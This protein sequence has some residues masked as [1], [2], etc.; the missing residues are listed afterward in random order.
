MGNRTK[1]AKDRSRST[2]SS[3][4]DANEG[5]AEEKTTAW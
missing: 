3:E 5:L 4:T 1:L 2:V